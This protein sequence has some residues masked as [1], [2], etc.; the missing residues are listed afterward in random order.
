MDVGTYTYIIVYFFDIPNFI[1]FIITISDIK[2]TS[3]HRFSRMI[4]VIFISMNTFIIFIIIWEHDS[5]YLHGYAVQ[6]KEKTYILYRLLS[7]CQLCS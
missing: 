6:I 1:S 4:G 5:D 3:S 2:V 7:I